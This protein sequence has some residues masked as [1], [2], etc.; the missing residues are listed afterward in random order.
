MYMGFSCGANEKTL[1]IVF[2]GVICLMKGHY[3]VFFSCGD[4]FYERIHR[5]IAL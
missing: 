3:A 4:M 2:H 5:Y 1:Y